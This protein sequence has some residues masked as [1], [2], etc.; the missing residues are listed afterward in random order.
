MAT[1][2]RIKILFRYLFCC[3]VCCSNILYTFSWVSVLIYHHQLELL[4][5]IIFASAIWHESSDAS[6]VRCAKEMEKNKLVD[7]GTDGGR[8]NAERLTHIFSWLVKKW[9]V[10]KF[11]FMGDG[12]MVVDNGRREWRKNHKNE[13]LVLWRPF[14]N[15]QFNFRK[16]HLKLVSYQDAVHQRINLILIFS[17]VIQNWLA[18]EMPE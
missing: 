8:L 17:W 13:R 5:A 6:G 4:P 3:R 1:G 15:I 7:D 9:H 2:D 12:R 18:F 16:N 14:M 10:M 11:W